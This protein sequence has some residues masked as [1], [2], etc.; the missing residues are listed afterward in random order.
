MGLIF[1]RHAYSRY[2]AVKPAI[3]ASLPSRSGKTRALTTEDFPQRGAIFLHPEAEFDYLVA[4]PDSADRAAAI[5]SALESI[6]ADY[7]TLRGVLPKAEY[8]KLSNDVLGDLLRRLNPEELK[9]VDG[10]IFGRIYEYFLTQFAD[11]GAHDGGEFF[12]FWRNKRLPRLEISRPGA[13]WLC[14]GF[15]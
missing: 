4:L 1:L 6:E 11:Q 9:K 15:P 10:D 3:G 13:R 8:H 14:F 2:Q 12:N 5:I 7:E